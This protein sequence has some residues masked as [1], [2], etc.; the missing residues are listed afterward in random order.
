MNLR[1]LEMPQTH[2][3]LIQTYRTYYHLFYIEMVRMSN[4]ALPDYIDSYIQMLEAFSRKPY[5]PGNTQRVSIGVI[6][7]HSFG[8]RDFDKLSLL[9]DRIIPQ[10]NLELV[11]FTSW[12]AGTLVHHPD[13]TTSRYV[14]HLIERAVGWIR[15]YGR[16]ARFLAAVNLLISIAKSAGD[17]TVVFL[18]VLEAASWQ[19]LS[20]PSL[21]VLYDTAEFYK[22]LTESLIRYGRSELYNYL[23]F[24]YELCVRL[25]SYGHFTKEYAA[26]LLLGKFIM[27]NPDFYIRFIPEIWSL[28]D[29]T[30]QSEHTQIKALS[31]WVSCTLSTV[32]TKLYL[33]QI[34]EESFEYVD[35]FID[36]HP[37]EFN[38]GIE[39]LLRK[40]KPEFEEKIDLLINYSRRMIETRHFNE[41]FALL[42]MLTK[43]YTHRL[44]Q[45]DQDL[46]IQLLSAPF[47]NEYKTFVVNICNALEAPSGQI[48]KA[49]CD[50]VRKEINGP[51]PITTL[52]MISQLPGCVFA[53]QN[54]L[55]HLINHLS[56]HES[57]LARAAVPSALYNIAV[58]TNIIKFDDLI[59]KLLK[60]AIYDENLHVRY[61]ILEVIH[62]NCSVQIAKPEYLKLLQV[63]VNDD[64][65][66]VRKI[67]LKILGKLSKFN[68]IYVT[69]ITRKALLDYFFILKNV[70][71]IRQRTRIARILPD[72]VSACSNTI[73]AYSNSLIEIF[74]N[75]FENANPTRII[76]FMEANADK[77]LIIGLINS[78][79]LLAPND[80]ETISKHI[81]QLIAPLCNYLIPGEQRNLILSILRFLEV[82]FK[83]PCSTVEVRTNAPKI[84]SMLSTLLAGTRSR[85]QRIQIL[86]V[87]GSIGVLEVHHKTKI[88]ASDV[89]LNVDDSLAR[90]FYHPNRD[91]E[92]EID[93]CI[94][95]KPN[96]IEQYNISV[97]ISSLFAIFKDETKTD[98]FYDTIQALVQVLSN[99]RN[100]ALGY[101]DD[102]VTRLLD[103]IAKSPKEQMRQYL[104]L[105]A[106]LISKSSHNASPFIARTLEIMHEHFCSELS[107]YFLDVILAFLHAIKDGFSPYSSETIC[108]LIILLDESKTCDIEVSKKVLAAFT[109]I[110][111]FAIDQ[112][113]L[114]IPQICDAVVCAQSLPLVRVMALEA[115][116]VLV[117]QN[118][119]FQFIGPIVRSVTCSILYNDEQTK[120]ASKQLLAV[121]LKNKGYDFFI[122][123][124]Q[125]SE[126]YS[127]L[128]Q[129]IQSLGDNKVENI[130]ATSL[131]LPLNVAQRN[132]S[133]KVFSED[134]IIAR[135]I[136]PNLGHGKHVEQWLQNFII[137]L[138]SNSPSESIRACA[139]LAISHQPLVYDLFNSAFHS[140]WN[141]L[142]DK[143]KAIICE[144]FKA[145][146]CAT[147]NYETVAREIIDLLV[148]M[149]MIQKPLEIGRAHV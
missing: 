123:I 95:F 43:K 23:S 92:G 76:N 96:Q 21:Q 105:Y 20:N 41:S 16:R 6:S 35:E 50:R 135:A 84:L 79:S 1:D 91:T 119:L 145:I 28:I 86:K 49:I 72:L 14:S 114:I 87:I 12:C 144:S 25:L 98:L 73:K 53:G 138:I 129:L 110:G 67:T 88:Q 10:T 147:E 128:S 70:P 63:F 47:S 45:I 3:G 58:S 141:I 143:T 149:H 80:P 100:F 8:F 11:R 2:E 18:P 125:T 136:M 78:M 39:I 46:I 101:F 94:L 56:T 71:S 13:A 83:P 30:F 127:I 102:F 64:A 9:F 146:L 29:D 77:D 31:F 65:Y 36:D 40:A 90:Q 34:C 140:C 124:D 106:E 75:T 112:R 139:T 134:T 132:S 24:F 19:L 38:K 103:V 104:P 15:S 113:Y 37:M 68:P 69:S 32:D 89:L 48:C 118:N 131:H 62:N 5:I 4:T 126:D 99:P 44:N 59:K 74:F 82:L 33:D 120:E 7:L 97:V 148:F 55:V 142:Q 130:T 108:L 81:D 111:N 54:D 117:A 22:A 26:L 60:L 52:E 133:Q 137:A 61:A 51:N 116:R 27:C 121:L 107:I 122:Q 85:K 42:T 66:T 17:S 57:S 109:I 115:L 93:E